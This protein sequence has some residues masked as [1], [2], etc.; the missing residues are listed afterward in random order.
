M[1]TA[2]SFVCVS[3]RWEV[4]KW[5]RKCLDEQGSS[6]N[7]ASKAWFWGAGGRRGDQQT[8]LRCV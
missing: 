4:V 7:H 1:L 2:V 8:G 5:L 3:R 6:M